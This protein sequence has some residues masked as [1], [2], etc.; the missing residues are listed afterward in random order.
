MIRR[1]R[2]SSTSGP[3]HWKRGWTPSRQANWGSN[4]DRRDEPHHP[5]RLYRMPVLGGRREARRKPSRGNRRARS[6]DRTHTGD[7]RS[8]PC[9]I[10]RAASVQEN[11]WT[12]RR[13]VAASE[14]GGAGTYGLAGCTDAEAGEDDEEDEP[15]VEV[16]GE[17]GTS[18]E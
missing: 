7:D 10:G 17:A 5:S 15:E 14:V 4:E 11:H 8:R 2:Q 1:R 6:R 3:R 12:R 18:S 9:S 16:S 13:L